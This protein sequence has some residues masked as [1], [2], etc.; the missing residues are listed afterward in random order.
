MRTAA[1]ARQP[2]GRL[3]RLR[4]PSRAAGLLFVCVFVCLFVCLLA[5]QVGTQVRATQNRVEA[6]IKKTIAKRT[7]ELR[8]AKAIERS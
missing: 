8:R 6:S 1:L 7:T 5:R 2:H 3:P 4:F